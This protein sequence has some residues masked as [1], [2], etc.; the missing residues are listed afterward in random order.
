MSEVRV[1]QRLWIYLDKD[2]LSSA[3]LGRVF[4][5]YFVTLIIVIKRNTQYWDNVYIYGKNSRFAEQL[6]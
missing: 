5:R 3:Q 6:H 4:N 1:R 2:R